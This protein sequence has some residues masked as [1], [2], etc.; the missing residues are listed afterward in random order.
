MSCCRYQEL[1]AALSLAEQHLNQSDQQT[2]FTDLKQQVAHLEAELNSKNVR[3]DQL[4]KDLQQ[5]EAAK[6]HA[7]DKLAAFTK[8]QQA[9]QVCYLLNSDV[10]RRCACAFYMAP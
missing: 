8:Q 2:A 7:T 10:L 4:H 5:A 6:Q 1:E 3:A 9:M